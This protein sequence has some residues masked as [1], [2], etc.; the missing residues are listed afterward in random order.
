[1]NI[2]IIFLLALVIDATVNTYAQ[3]TVLAPAFNFWSICLKVKFQ[4]HMKS[5]F[6][7]FLR[8][9]QLYEFHSCW[10]DQIAEKRSFRMEKSLVAGGQGMCD[11]TRMELG[12]PISQ[13]TR[14]QRTLARSRVKLWSSKACTQWATPTRH[15]S[16]LKAP[17]TP[18][19][20][21]PAEDLVCIHTIL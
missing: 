10:C 21:S 11:G 17:T 16:C 20:M 18:K 1:M 5:L 3:I 4:D 9:I 19:T 2:C 13:Q 15:V 14:K 12:L 7:I 6:F 8:K